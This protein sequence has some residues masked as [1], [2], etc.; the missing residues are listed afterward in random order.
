MIEKLFIKNVALI[1]ELEVEFKEGLN[2]LTGETGAGKSIIIDSINFM[3]G[4]KADRSFIHSG[5]DFAEVSALV[6]VENS[7]NIEQLK[8]NEVELAEDNTVLLSRTM[9]SDGKTTCKINGKTVTLGMLKDI[10][11]L[12]VDVHGQYEHQSLLKPEKHLE[13]L[14]RL[15]GNN[16]ADNLEKLKERYKSYKDV[17]KCLDEISDDDSN[18]DAK[19]DMCKFQIDEIKMANI[20]PHEEEELAEKKAKI[21]NGVKLKEFSNTAL[22]ALYR[23]E[24]GSASDRIAEAIGEVN[25][26]LRLD[27]SASDLYEELEALAAGLED[28]VNK[29]RNY[30]ENVESDPRLLDELELRSQLIY[31]MKKKYG[32][33]IEE[34]EQFAKDAKDRL[35]FLEN[36][37]EM[38]MEYTIRK[39]ADERIVAKLCDEIGTVREEFA[40][41]V[42]KDIEDVLYDLGMVNA[43][44]KIDVQKKPDY[45]AKGN[46][47]VEFLMSA[48][49]GEEPKPLS[50]IASGGE[51][52]R[53][54]LALK[55]IL[56]KV[57]NIETFIFDEI[58]AGISG[59]TAQRVAEKLAVISKNH[60]ILCITHLPQIAAM[61]DTHFFIEKNSF[62]GSTQVSVNEL[63]G[64]AV[65]VELARLIGGAKITDAT[66]KAAEE[67]KEMANKLK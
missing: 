23:S 67:M 38:I 7:E 8:Q 61:A 40:A 10:A 63:M 55:V 1:E 29:L 57:D 18:R 4:E 16:V 52:S 2:I 43:V 3:L 45:S 30:N 42:C 47:K 27:E 60:Q 64:E 56:S 25:S 44:F 21:A 62:D 49:L 20:K 46:D 24:D 5:S 15:C 39:E 48:N 34:I 59:R 32:N 6:L 58:D 26:I 13:L 54:M 37:E 35:A 11:E 17:C 19:I 12:I 36:S 14:D 50:K 22:E 28:V 33:T 66:M 41:M 51:M 31:D 9:N 65:T 53:V